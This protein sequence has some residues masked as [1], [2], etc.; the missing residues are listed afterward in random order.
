MNFR[1]ACRS[2]WSFISSEGSGAGGRN[3]GGILVDCPK[4]SSESQSSI[5]SACHSSERRPEL[6]TDGL[7]LADL[8]TALAFRSRAA[9]SP[10]CF[11]CL[12]AFVPDARPLLAC[13][14]MTR[15]PGPAG[16]ATTC[17]NKSLCTYEADEL[18]ASGRDEDCCAGRRDGPAVA[19]PL[20]VRWNGRG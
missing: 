16:C 2:N 1:A 3:G 20:I 17:P 6:P 14:D 8:L 7:S 12:D 5:A 13:E 9:E 4:I 10:H 11:V 19:L 15:R 18:R